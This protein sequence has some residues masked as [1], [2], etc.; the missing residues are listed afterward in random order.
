MRG[1][2]TMP[3]RVPHFVP[4]RIIRFR[5]REVETRPNAYQRGY[6]DDAHR[7]WRLAVL[8]RDN[9][10]CRDCGCVCWDRKT[11]HADHLV[12]IVE[13][14]H[15]RYSVGNGQCLCV[16]C[17]GRKTRGEQIKSARS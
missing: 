8:N 10:T 13:A 9:W 1:E 5:P 12:P 3:K 2:V 14:P 4:P 15:L 6:C 16:R 11:A 7:A 17:H